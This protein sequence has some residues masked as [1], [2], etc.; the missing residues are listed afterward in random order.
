VRKGVSQ[1]WPAILSALKSSLEGVGAPAY[2][3]WGEAAR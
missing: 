1:G 3:K 2:V